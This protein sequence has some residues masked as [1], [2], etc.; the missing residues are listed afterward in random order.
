[1][2]MRDTIH[3]VAIEA[4][5][6]PLL[7]TEIVDKVR[8]YQRGKHTL[9]VG[10]TPQGATTGLIELI[11]TEDGVE[12]GFQV[13]YRDKGKAAQIIAWLRKTAS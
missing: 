8:I 6:A 1:M 11:E 2:N 10:Y 13:S 5:W 7:G 12:R 4:G 9:L 3:E